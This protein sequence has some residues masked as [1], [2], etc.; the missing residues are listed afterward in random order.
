MEDQLTQLRSDLGRQGQEYQLLLDIK[1]RLEVEITEYRRLL[2]GEGVGY[3][4]HTGSSKCRHQ[5][6]LKSNAPCQN[7]EGSSNV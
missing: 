1:T 6:V 4:S 2:E 3:E 5:L 7:Q